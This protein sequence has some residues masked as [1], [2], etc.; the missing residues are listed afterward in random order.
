MAAAQA[1]AA[2]YY[3]LTEFTD[4]IAWVRERRAVYVRRFLDCRRSPSYIMT[5]AGNISV[6]S[7]PWMEEDT[8]GWQVA[9][10]SRR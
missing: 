1:A 9:H 4:D 10:H 2:A 7:V 8:K 5:L 3:P 6:D